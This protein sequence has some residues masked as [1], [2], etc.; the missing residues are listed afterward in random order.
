MSGTGLSFWWA[1]KTAC[2]LLRSG[3]R[4]SGWDHG[5]EWTAE[6]HWIMVVIW[7]PSKPRRVIS[8]SEFIICYL[9]FECSVTFL[10]S[11]FLF[12]RVVYLLMMFNRCIHINLFNIYIYILESLFICTK[13]IYVHVS[14]S[15]FVIIVSWNIFF[16]TVR[17]TVHHITVYYISSFIIY[18][19]YLELIVWRIKRW[20]FWCFTD[21][22]WHVLNSGSNHC[23]FSACS[24][25]VSYV[26]KQPLIM[27]CFMFFFFF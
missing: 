10:I 16:P 18:S 6:T 9:L 12:V 15:M 17:T 21:I 1:R 8:S 24:Q 3:V 5:Q 11:L 22:T 13:A 4:G 25:A 7:L 19:D 27:V 26:S 2:D 23:T 14:N 20:P